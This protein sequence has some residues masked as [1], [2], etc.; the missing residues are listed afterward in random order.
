MARPCLTLA[1]LLAALALTTPIATAIEHGNETPRP[2][3]S[4]ALFEATSHRKFD[5][6]AQWTRVFDDPERDAWQKPTA[7]V[8]ALQLTPGALVADVGAGT[9]YFTHYLS[10]AVGPEGTVFAVETEPNMVTHLRERAEREHLSN[11]TPVLASFDNPRLPAGRVD[12]ILFVDTLHHVDARLGYL[13]RL[14]SSLTPAGRVAIIDLAEA[15]HSG[16]SENGSQA[17]ATT[18]RR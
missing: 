16:G 10:R 9:G 11:V 8:E 13:R 2:T 12:V 7:V 14:R 5:E 4:A 17:T 15:R 18:D 6:V 1:L 3:P